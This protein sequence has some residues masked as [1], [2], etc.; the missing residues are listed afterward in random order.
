MN[1]GDG[2]YVAMRKA[3]VRKEGAPPTQ[4]RS[5]RPPTMFL[6]LYAFPPRAWRWLV[7]VVFFVALALAWRLSR[8]LAWWA[9]PVAVCLAAVW[10]LVASPRLYLHS[11]LWG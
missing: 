7:G 5:V 4:V 9:G 1:R 6:L 8:P 3:L 10:L 11:E 2:Y